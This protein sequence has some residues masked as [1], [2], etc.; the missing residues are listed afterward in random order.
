LAKARQIRLKSFDADF[1]QRA[2]APHANAKR[3]PNRSGFDQ[4]CA[5]PH[6]DERKSIDGVE[7]WL[8]NEAAYVRQ[9]GY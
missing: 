6:A 4:A 1:F 2:L 5:Q 7:E 8:I 3:A 9:F